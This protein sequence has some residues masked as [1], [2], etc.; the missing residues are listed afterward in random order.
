VNGSFETFVMSFVISYQ[1]LFSCSPYHRTCLIFLLV[2][3]DTT[4]IKRTLK[5]KNVANGTG[6]VDLSLWLIRNIEVAIGICIVLNADGNL[7]GGSKLHIS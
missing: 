1:F 7:H 5:I 4:N 6:H 2:A 3:I